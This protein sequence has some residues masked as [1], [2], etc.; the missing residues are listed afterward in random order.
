MTKQSII[1]NE[2][3]KNTN[4]EPLWCEE[5][6]IYINGTI[7][8]SLHAEEHIQQILSSIQ[9]KQ[10]KQKQEQQEQNPSKELHIF[11]Y[12]S[13]CWNPGSTAN[14][15]VLANP[16]VSKQIAK[17]IGWK[18]C[19]CQQ[20]TDHRGDVNFYGLVCTLLHDDEIRLI[21]DLQRKRFYNKKNY[22]KNNS[23]DNGETDADVNVNVNVDVDADEVD[24]SMSMTEG[25]LYTI[26]SDLV[27]QCLEQLDFREKGG[28]ARDVID[29]VIQQH[30]Q[31]STLT[32]LKYEK[33]LLY[34]GTCRYNSILIQV[35]NNCFH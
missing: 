2:K 11:G 29:V 26:P 8:S 14:D 9:Q 19:W 5:Q 35:C 6:Q 18:R 12:G 17:A 31:G 32:E 34:R 22:G 27:E 21:H 25:V 10:Q 3:V 16:R 7:A 28:Y 4:N 24:S 30:Q 33:A 23:Y 15:D 13:L 20:S 1:H